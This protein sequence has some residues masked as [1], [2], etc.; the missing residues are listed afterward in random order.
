MYVTYIANPCVSDLEVRM[1]VFTENATP[2]KSSKSRNLD[3]FVLMQIEPNSQFE[4]VLRDT[5]ESGFLD[6]VEFWD[7]EFSV[8]SVMTYT[9]VWGIE[10]CNIW[11]CYL[12]VY[13]ICM[14]HLNI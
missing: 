3:S 11:M 14:R 2:Q 12:E 1:T 5:E 8:E 7:V 13:D 6:L 4:F 10:V 9:C